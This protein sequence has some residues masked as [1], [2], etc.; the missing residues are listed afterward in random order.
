MMPRPPIEYTPTDFSPAP[1]VKP[2]RRL[3]FFCERN[4]DAFVFGIAIGRGTPYMAPS[5]H[6]G[7]ALWA[8]GVEWLV[9][10]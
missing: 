4:E 1:V 2:K 3:R 9:D 8:I 10:V 5:V 7:F 6:V